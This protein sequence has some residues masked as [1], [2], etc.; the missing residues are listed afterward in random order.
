MLYARLH[1]DS[2]MSENIS[3]EFVLNLFAATRQ[4]RINGVTS[5]VGKDASGFFG[6]QARHASFMTTLV[7]GLAKFRI[8]KNPWQYLAMP[9]A[10]LYFKNNEL[11]LST[12]HFLLDADLERITATLQTR[13]ASQQEN[14]RVDRESPGRM[15]L[16]MLRR[17]M[18]LK[19]KTAWQ[20]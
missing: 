3:T 20:S 8:A 2:V 5:F 10:V 7:F 14:L 18:A 13:I 16:A 17:L 1:A 4:Q 12:R 19:R 15:E 11:T 6:I 9:G